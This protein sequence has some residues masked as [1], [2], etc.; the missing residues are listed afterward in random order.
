M[1]LDDR[2]FVMQCVITM[3]VPTSAVYFYPRLVPLHEIQNG[4]ETPE[5]PTAV[6]CTVEKMVDNGVYLLGK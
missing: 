4:S 1:T 5:V 2:S 6:R 3:D